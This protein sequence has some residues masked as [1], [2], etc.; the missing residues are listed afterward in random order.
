DAKDRLDAAVRSAPKPRLDPAK[1]RV[2]PAPVAVEDRAAAFHA[3]THG[4]PEG[5]RDF[6]S[7]H[8]EQQPDDH[9]AR[10][11]LVRA[12]RHV[13]EPKQ[14]QAVLEAAPPSWVD[15]REVLAT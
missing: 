14:A 4:N 6:L 11:A 8:L 1:P 13:G 7:A 10:L 3:L 15:P 12:L 9:D 5:A 2:R